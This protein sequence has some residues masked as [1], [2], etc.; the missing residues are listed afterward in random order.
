MTGGSGV[1]MGSCFGVNTGKTDLKIR[2]QDSPLS[3]PPTKD[4]A[5]NKLLNLG[6]KCAV[7]LDATDRVEPEL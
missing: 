7:D 4:R 2:P 1:A 6:L 5:G 3:M